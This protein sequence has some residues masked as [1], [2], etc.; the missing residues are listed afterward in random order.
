VAVEGHAR[1]VEALLS[2]EHFTAEAFQ[3]CVLIERRKPLL[4]GQDEEDIRLLWHICPFDLF[5]SWLS[6]S[7]LRRLP[8]S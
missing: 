7:Q 8:S 1:V 2:L 3:V 6:R 5:I 4:I